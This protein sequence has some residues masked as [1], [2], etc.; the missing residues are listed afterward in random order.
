MKNFII[1]LTVS[2][3]MNSSVANF[4]TFKTKLSPTKKVQLER[5]PSQVQSLI[6]NDYLIAKKLKNLKEINL[7]KQIISVS[8]TIQTDCEDTD[9]DTAIDIDIDNNE[10]YCYTCVPPST[11]RG[12][13]GSCISYGADSCF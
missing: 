5:L 12:G 13:D 2:L 9:I 7:L 1:M 4:E 10:E 6:Y 8:K 11:C 3:S